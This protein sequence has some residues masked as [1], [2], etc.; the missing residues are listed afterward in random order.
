ME[1]LLRLLPSPQP[2]AVRYGATAAMVLVTFSL[3]LGIEERG[4]A[5]GFILFIPALVATSLWR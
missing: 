4:G 3:R 2:A 1:T 5:Y